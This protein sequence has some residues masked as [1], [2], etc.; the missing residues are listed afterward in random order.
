MTTDSRRCPYLRNDV[1][2]YHLFDHQGTLGWWAYWYEITHPR[3]V[4]C[5]PLSV[6]LLRPTE[7]LKPVVKI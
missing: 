1:A 2:Y 4:A 7:W 3:A 5:T 6:A